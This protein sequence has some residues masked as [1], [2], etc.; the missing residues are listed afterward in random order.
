M[1]LDVDRSLVR[2]RVRTQA[3][4]S[5][6]P[7]HRGVAGGSVN[8]RTRRS[9][10]RRAPDVGVR[11]VSSGRAAAGSHPPRAERC[12][13]AAVSEEPDFDVSWVTTASVPMTA[14]VASPMASEGIVCPSTRPMTPITTSTVAA[15]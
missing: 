13:H 11:C 12:D 4:P 7:G 10:S 6:P 5:E 15:T 2:K 9:S 14:T 8:R 3:E 1:A